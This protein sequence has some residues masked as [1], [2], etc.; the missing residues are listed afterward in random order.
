MSPGTT[1]G[2]ET[3]KGSANATGFASLELLVS[4]I[5][6]VLTRADAAIA[7]AAL[8]RRR[9]PAPV[10]PAP[11]WAPT[12]TPA[13][14]PAAKKSS[15]CMTVIVLSVVGLSVF[16]LFGDKSK[17][18]QG[19]ASTSGSSIP[20]EKRRAPEPS[21]QNPASPPVAQGTLPP[22]AQ[23]PSPPVGNTKPPR[24]MKSA[25]PTRAAAAPAD[26]PVASR[27]GDRSAWKQRMEME[28]AALEKE[29]DA[30]DA[31]AN[32]LERLRARIALH[33]A[34]NIGADVVSDEVVREYD[35]L[36]DEHNSSLG[37]LKAWAARHQARVDAFNADVNRYNSSL[38]K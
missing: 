11:A 18:A 8:R 24:S 9:A 12:A 33:E 17:P 10:V 1:V 36:I 16:A 27:T 21:A 6:P 37:A 13:R 26:V 25:A 15:G 7:E 32:R 38:R 30:L 22:W 35:Y 3:A 28:R 20:Y 29:S 31:E 23:A 2:V 14:A 19:A 34:E 5:A 4:D